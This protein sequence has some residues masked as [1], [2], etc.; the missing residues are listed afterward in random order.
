MKKEINLPPSPLAQLFE[1]AAQC[2][3]LT[4]IVTTAL[5]FNAYFTSPLVHKYLLG[6]TLALAAWFFYLS[7]SIA[8]RRFVFVWS[9]YYYPTLALVVW[10]GIGSLYAPQSSARSNYFVFFLIVSA[11]P[12]W[13]TY[14]RSARFRSL[15]MWTVF[16]A[17]FCM[18]LACVRQLVMED[19]RLD[20]SFFKAMTISRG[21]YERQNMGAF[22]GHNNASTAYVWIGCLYAIGLWHVFRRHLW[23]ALF[24]LFVMVGL[25]VIF[26]G[27]SRGVA[28]A[29]IPSLALILYG[30]Y[31]DWRRKGAPVSDEAEAAGAAF[32]RK[33]KIGIPVFAAGII[34]IFIMLINAPFAKRKIEGVFSRFQVSTEILAS[35]TYPRVWWMSLLMVADHPLTGVGFA[36]WPYEYPYTQEQWFEQYPQTKI[37]LP[38]I[39]QH[40]ER[41][42]NDFLQT[43]AELGI[44]GLFCIFWLLI[45]HFQSILSLFRRRP[46]PFPGLVASAATFATMIHACVAFPFHEAAAS[47]LFLGNLALVSWFAC[48]KEME[49]APAWLNN[50]RQTLHWWIVPA[51]FG[52]SMILFRPITTNLTGDYIA[53]KNGIND[54]QAR[55]L[56]DEYFIAW[57]GSDGL[58][59]TQGRIKHIEDGY[60]HL[61]YSLTYLPDAG[62]NLYTLGIAAME[63]ARRAGDEQLYLKAIQY[64]NDSLND[65]TFYESY[66]YLGRAYRLVWEL[67][68]KPEYL[69]AAIENFQKAT[70]I[71]PT[72][73]EGWVQ[74]GLLYAKGGQE[75]KALELFGE[76]ELRF[77]GF[78]EIGVLEGARAAN[79][80]GDHETASL[81]FNL[82]AATSPSNP[83]IFHETIDYYLQLGRMDLAKRMLV[84]LS[85]FQ[86]EMTS[87]KVMNKVLME[88]LSRKDWP[89]A[90]S[91]MNGL[92][93]KEALRSR[94]ALWYYA[95]LTAWICGNPWESLAHW[96]QASGLGVTPEQLNEPVSAAWGIIRF[97]Q[98]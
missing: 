62:N 85:E 32:K 92:L 23:Q 44:P 16:F 35:G 19:P 64:L 96:K 42:H 47:C 84:G 38:P 69:T 68:K 43:W 53:R 70:A 71:M 76:T 13:V 52:V 18:T 59:A 97:L 30:L 90:R 50:P 17:G 21:D 54:Q 2:C 89:N 60:K 77:P 86:D 33:L 78:T 31:Y 91:L 98:P 36:A 94:P 3:L 6:Q 74:L 95:G 79:A 72:F 28:M 83:L 24:G 20:F 93:E 66:G 34:L 57:Y 9:P 80:Q 27:G 46:I 15:F 26:Y 81:L 82:A 61:Q 87:A 8:A 75:Q 58:S 39:G 40:T 12:L 67:T 25:T 1:R 88:L 29:V 49:W 51:A 55:T 11:F 48:S 22:L 45:V 73:M 41:A 4:L 5:Y 56:D 63:K 65:Y 7:Q 10:A 37:G 14:F